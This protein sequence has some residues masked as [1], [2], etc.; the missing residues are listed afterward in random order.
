M[1]CSCKMTHSDREAQYIKETGDKRPDFKDY[2]N[3]LRYSY[4]ADYDEWKNGFISWLSKRLEKAEEENR[5]TKEF[6]MRLAEEGGVIISSNDCSKLEISTA[7]ACGRFL[8][9]D[10]FGFVLR[11][12]LTMVK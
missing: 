1:K 4:E 2:G 11:L 3:D 10:S 7:R 6:V 5:G 12:K 8:I 9:I